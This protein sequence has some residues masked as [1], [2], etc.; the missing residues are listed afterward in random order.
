[1]TLQ[2]TLKSNKYLDYKTAVKLT[3]W[4]NSVILNQADARIEE[5]IIKTLRLREKTFDPKKGNLLSY[6]KTSINFDVLKLKT[7]PKLDYHSFLL[8]RETT[9]PVVDMSKFTDREIVAMYNVYRN[10][11][12]QEDIDIV[13]GLEC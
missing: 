13:K 6:L 2:E 8:T 4:I 5:R 9:S 12:T 3:S 10:T 7:T 1:M 11:A